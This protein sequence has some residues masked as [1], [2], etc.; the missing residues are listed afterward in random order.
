MKG[1]FNPAE[2]LR[3]LGLSRNAR[4]VVDFGSG[5]GTF[6][7]PTAEMIEGEVIGLDIEPRRAWTPKNSAKNIAARL[8]Q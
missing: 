1:I 6:S 2:M 3:A 8:I 5:Y 4:P 7:L